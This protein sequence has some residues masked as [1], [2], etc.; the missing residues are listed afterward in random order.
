VKNA[1]NKYNVHV[2]AE[3]AYKRYDRLRIYNRPGTPE[4]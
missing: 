4:N 3:E 1:E 2:F